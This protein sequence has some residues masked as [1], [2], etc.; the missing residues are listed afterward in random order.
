M[1]SVRNVLVP[2]DFSKASWGV[3]KYALEAEEYKNDH[4]V[5]LHAYRLIADDFPDQRDS[6]VEWK[7][8]IENKLLKTYSTFSADLDFSKNK[9]QVEFKMEVGFTVNCIRSLCRQN[10]I[11]LVLYAINGSKKNEQ[12][13]DLIKLDCSP[14]KLVSE[15]LDTNQK[16]LLFNEDIS[17]EDFFDRWNDCLLRIRENPKLSFTVAPD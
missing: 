3:V 8:S 6:P 2:I 1:I 4:L 5:L 14:I 13:A 16:S 12:L 15:K 10:K 17:K 7:K 9:N 11:D